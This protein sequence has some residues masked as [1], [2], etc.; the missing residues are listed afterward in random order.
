MSRFVLIAMT[1]TALV[2]SLATAGS[3]ASAPE[4]TIPVLSQ[5]SAGVTPVYYTWHGHRYSHRR[6]DR[7]HR[8]WRYY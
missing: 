1:A 3:A 6:W 8:R 7:R 2:L 5:Q 4:A